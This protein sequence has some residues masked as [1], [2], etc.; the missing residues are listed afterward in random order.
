[1][2]QDLCCT[3]AVDV[4]GNFRP[5]GG[6][7]YK[8]KAASDLGKTTIILLEAMRSEFDKI[9]LDER[10]GI[11]ACYAS[12]IKDLIEKVFPPKKKD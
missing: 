1:M 11:E 5:V 3:G 9:H 8:L 2:T 7:K 12:N 6:L 10:F 4:S